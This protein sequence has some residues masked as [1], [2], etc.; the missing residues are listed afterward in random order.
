[1]EE[2]NFNPETW[3]TSFEMSETEYSFCAGLTAILASIWPQWLNPVIPTVSRLWPVARE[4]EGDSLRKYCDDYV[5]NYVHGTYIPALK[6]LGFHPDTVDRGLH[7]GM[8]DGDM[9][10]LQSVIR[11]AGS[12]ALRVLHEV[13]RFPP[14]ELAW[15]QEDS[16][17]FDRV[18]KIV[19]HII[20]VRCSYTVNGVK[21]REPRNHRKMGLAIH[22]VDHSYVY[23]T[24]WIDVIDDSSH[25]V[26]AGELG[27][28][29][30]SRGEEIHD[31]Q[32]RV[33]LYIVPKEDE[34]FDRYLVPRTCEADPHSYRLATVEMSDSAV[35]EI[36][37][38]LYKLRSLDRDHYKL[39]WEDD[40]CPLKRYS[41]IYEIV[42]SAEL[43]PVSDDELSSFDGNWDLT[44]CF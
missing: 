33:R 6:A 19:P 41:R 26:T 39:D 22:P 42:L 4:Q 40:Y 14:D 38:K 30:Y 25:L 34:G 17:L 29:C 27:R 1:M 18:D 24:I 9:S 11:E 13:F 7:P 8:T 37:H 3:L 15:M 28:F 2:E 5:Q 31:G 10:E 16:P 36:E 23:D 43:H 35:E 20:D 12:W 21:I 44:H 32:D